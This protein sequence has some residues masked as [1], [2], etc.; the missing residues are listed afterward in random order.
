MRR[1]RAGELPAALPLEF[2]HEGRCRLA[3]GATAEFF[4]RRF[5]PNSK[6]S[7][8]YSPDFNTYDGFSPAPQ[9]LTYIADI[10]LTGLA[11][12]GNDGRS[13]EADSP[14]LIIDAET[15]EKQPHWVELDQQVLGRKNDPS[16]Q[17]LY[18]RPSKKL[19]WGRRYIVALRNL[20]NSKGATV[21]SSAAFTAIRDKTPT[22]EPGIEARRPAIDAVLNTLDGF[23]IA[24]ASVNL[25]WDFTTMSEGRATKRLLKMADEKGV[26]FKVLC[27]ALADPLYRHVDALSQVSPHKLL[28][29]E[30][31][32]HK[33]VMMRNQLRVLEQKINSSEALTSAD[34]FDWQQYVTRCYGSMTTFNLLFKDK[35]SWF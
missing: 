15:G 24:R 29:I 26:D 14:T 4:A 10:S 30:Q 7:R 18:I 13:I 27:V 22:N 8:A 19:A 12:Q 9:I 28:E 1:R 35:E 2:L 23:G 31:F 32:F 16:V 33:L 11:T 3:D 20:K 17:M 6:G 5:P 34:K 21:E 25:A